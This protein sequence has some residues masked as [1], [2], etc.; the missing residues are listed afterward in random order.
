MEQE[1]INY[2]IKMDMPYMISMSGGRT[3]GMMAK[4]M[5]DNI[6]EDQRIVCFA[7]TGKE[8]EET[9]FFVQ[10]IEN[11]F[12]IKVHWLEYDD[13][14]EGFRVVD[15]ETASRN[16]EPYAKLIKKRKYLPNAVTRY[17]TTELK[18][19]P[20][21]KFMQSLGFSEWYN[22]IGIRY[23]EPRRYNRLANA[24]SKEPYESIAPLY[25]MRITKPMVLNFWAKQSFDLNIP[26]YLGNCDMCF[27]K[28]RAKLKEIIKKE[29]NRVRWWVEQENATG[30]TFRNGL[31]Y[32]RL[33]YM[34][35]TAPELFDSD[36]EIE[37]FCTTD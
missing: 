4:I 7:N 1:Q 35:K 12:G 10:N 6:P 20:I 13:T 26:N 15:Y 34:V 37:C 8:H 33:V 32:E 14:P 25:D 11:N 22:A 17:C 2:S 19:R 3:S 31:S 5:C 29:P 24:C 9:L 30:K 18:I 27:L 23:D 21:K 36:L 28:S 16:G